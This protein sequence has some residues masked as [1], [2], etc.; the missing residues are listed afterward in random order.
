MKKLMKK[1]LP[2][3]PS[4]THPMIRAAGCL[5]SF[6]SLTGLGAPLAAP[7]PT[8]SLPPPRLVGAGCEPKKKKG[9]DSF[10]LP[11][12]AYRSTLARKWQELY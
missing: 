2:P 1:L 9:G 12:Y 8:K 5:H 4:P 10:F 6:P 3:T 7:S 11:T